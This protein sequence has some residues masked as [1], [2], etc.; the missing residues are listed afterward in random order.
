MLTAQSGG[1]SIAG[2]GTDIARVDRIA[3]AYARHG[4]RFALRILGEREWEAQ[5]L[6]VKELATAEQN[7]VAITDIVTFVMGRFSAK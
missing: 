6:S 1:A 4:D 5:Q 7:D 3:A 2:I